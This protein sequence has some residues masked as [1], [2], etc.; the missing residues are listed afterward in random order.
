LDIPLVHTF[1]KL[2]QTWHS[3][4]LQFPKIERYTLATTCSA[5][6]LNALE[7]IL[8][9]SATSDPTLKLRQLQFASTKVDLLR[10]L[11]RLSKDTKCISNGAYLEIESSLHETGRML[12]GWLK[13]L[14]KQ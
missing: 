8:A 4:S 6:I 3:L 11:V 1:Y 7:A 5:N 10:L 12:G 9:A 2:Y 14:P 13:T